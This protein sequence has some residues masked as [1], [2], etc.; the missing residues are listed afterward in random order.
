MV[1]GIWCSFFVVFIDEMNTA[2][3]MQKSDTCKVTFAKS[4]IWDIISRMSTFW[5]KILSL[6]RAE[7]HNINSIQLDYH[8]MK[9]LIII[10]YAYTIQW[11]YHT[12]KFYVQYE[13]SY[14]YYD[15]LQ[16]H[17]FNVQWLEVS[18]RYLYILVNVLKW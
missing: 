2:M 14:L 12:V 8:N 4:K 5:E 18:F 10:Q 16:V 11:D 3:C 13:K 7:N 17:R 9:F 6:F 1:Q 15:T